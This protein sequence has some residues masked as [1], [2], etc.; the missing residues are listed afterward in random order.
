M[1]RKLK[2]VVS[3]LAQYSRFLVSKKHK[4]NVGAGGLN[5]DPNW[6]PTDIRLLNL[7][8]D[9]HWRRILP[10]S[11]RLDN[12]MAEHVWEHLSDRD[13]ELANANCFKYL[14]SNGVLR[15]AVPDGYM[16]DPAYIEDV[17]PGGKGA[18]A[19]D[20][21]LLYNYKI[22]TERLEKAGF[23]VQLLEYWDEQG[24]FHHTDWT[25]ENGYIERSRRYCPRNKGGKLVY[26][27]L[28]VDAIKP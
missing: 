19:D 7:T 26:T 23:K 9:A 13:T 8:K 16:P 14:K 11:I 4:F 21:K 12:I 28:I 1:M 6:F 18:G 22:M 24:Q 15:L 10:F 3:V 20:H 25:N 5:P 27:S 2:K 17:R